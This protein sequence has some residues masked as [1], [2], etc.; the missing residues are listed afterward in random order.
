MLF[1]L[2]IVFFGSAAVALFTAGQRPLGVWFG[3]IFAINIALIY[4]LG[5]GTLGQ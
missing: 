2:Q 5:P 4:L 3:V 1:F